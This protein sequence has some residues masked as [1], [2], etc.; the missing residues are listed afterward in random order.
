MQW[1]RN[2]SWR[3]YIRANVVV[4]NEMIKARFGRIFMVAIMES[5]EHGKV[6]GSSIQGRSS[7]VEG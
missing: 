7:L 1:T 6:D 5:V 4:A 2:R 3:G